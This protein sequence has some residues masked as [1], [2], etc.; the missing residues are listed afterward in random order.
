MFN[1]GTGSAELRSRPERS[2]RRSETW[3]NWLTTC[4]TIGGA[5]YSIRFCFLKINPIEKIPKLG[6]DVVCLRLREVLFETVDRSVDRCLVEGGRRFKA[7]ECWLLTCV[8]LVEKIPNPEGEAGGWPPCEIPFLTVGGGL[9][10][11]GAG[12]EP[13]LPC[14]PAQVFT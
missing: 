1:G 7:V 8:T 9:V 11:Q 6:V 12:V 3:M 4:V 14:V 2:L 10:E 13:R 5:I